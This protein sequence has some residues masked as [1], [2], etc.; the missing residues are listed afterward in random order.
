MGIRAVRLIFL[1][2]MCGILIGGWQFD[3]ASAQENDLSR[4]K[5][6]LYWPANDGFGVCIQCKTNKDNKF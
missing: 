2:K 5:R 3:H 4:E 1:L 6:T